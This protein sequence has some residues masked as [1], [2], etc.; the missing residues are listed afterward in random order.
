MILTP[1]QVL[2][3][4]N[5]PP[6]TPLFVRVVCGGLQLPNVI[7]AD[8]ATRQYKQRLPDGTVIDGVYERIEVLAVDPDLVPLS[9][10]T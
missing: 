4:K 8:P 10:K 9:E 2:F 1:N 3:A 6:N 7:W 5:L